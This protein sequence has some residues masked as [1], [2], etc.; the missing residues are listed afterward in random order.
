MGSM[1]FRVKLLPVP[2]AK[3]AGKTG[4]NIEK[5]V[6]LAQAGVSADL[7]DFLF[8]LRYI[9]TQF[10][11]GVS[12]EK[13]DKNVQ[14]NSARFTPEQKELLTSLDNGARVF[15][16]NIKANGPNGVVDLRDIHFTI[17]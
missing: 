8:D 13:G 9:V 2:I 7:E 17:N 5:N 1:A 12:T 6:L 3:V 4:G 14:S 16:T 10:T 11:V 15:I